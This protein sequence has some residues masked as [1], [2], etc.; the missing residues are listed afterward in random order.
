MKII[1]TGVN[2]QLGQFIVEYLQKNQGNIEIIGTIRHKSYDNQKYIFDKNSIIFELMDLSDVHSIEN[3]II[4]YKP[5][6]FINTAANA[7]VGESWAVPVQHIEQNTIAVLHQLESIRKHS[8][9]TRYFNMGSSEELGCTENNGLQNEFTRIDPK[10]PYGCS[11]AAA[12]YLIN[13]Y[14]NSYNLYALQN[15]TFNFESELR[16]EKYI[17]KKITM[18]VS[19]IKKSIEYGKIFYPIEV[20]NLNSIRSWQFAGDVGDSIW[21]TLNQEIYNCDL[22]YDLDL[23]LD[24]KWKFLTRNIKEYVVSSSESHSIR[25]L[26]DTAFGCIGIRGKW[27]GENINEKY[28]TDDM[29][30]L[31]IVNPKYFR[32]SDVTFLNGDSTLIQK[33][34]GWKPTLTF[35]TLIQRMVDY[36]VENIVK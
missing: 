16:G 36:D 24:N 22:K 1:I 33:E 23:C 3:L 20:G 17:T 15:I 9:L 14:R 8:P 30:P 25:E 5:D 6:Y 18:G 7:F 10:S 13:V 27:I 19:R 21:R 34:L 35:K 29:I 31:V 12:R 28:V 2:G 11:K 26:I 4:K 32:L